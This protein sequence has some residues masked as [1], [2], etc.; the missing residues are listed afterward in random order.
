[1]WQLMWQVTMVNIYKMQS[2]HFKPAVEC[3]S[4]VKRMR[5]GEEKLIKKR[6]LTSAGQKKPRV[7]CR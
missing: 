6:S 1:M 7:A 5:R 2:R 4:V 3:R